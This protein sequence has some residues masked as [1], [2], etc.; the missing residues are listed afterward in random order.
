MPDRQNFLLGHGE[1]LV[2]AIPAPTGGGGPSPPYT[3]EQALARLAPLVRTAVD[4][5]TDLPNDACP[6]DR[7]VGVVTMH[8]QRIAKSYF[9]ERLFGDFGFEAVG[10]RP[11]T[12]QPK[13]WSRRG[14]P[15]PSPSTELF[16]AGD[17][18]AFRTWASALNRGELGS[19][20][21]RDGLVSIESFRAPS[22]AEPLRGI[23]PEDDDDAVEGLFEVVL[24]AS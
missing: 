12:V 3:Y 24:H 2:T 17:R 5:I 13:A 21:A 9:P 15:E 14:E 18:R 7:A 4:E 20:Q 6:N 8:P 1:R 23:G 16:V 19:Q 10:S 11:V 22:A